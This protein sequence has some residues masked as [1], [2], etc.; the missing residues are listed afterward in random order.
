MDAFIEFQIQ[1]TLFLQ[2][3][4]VWLEA[5]MQAFPSSAVNYSSCL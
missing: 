1:F 4:G 3:L 5:P 2:N